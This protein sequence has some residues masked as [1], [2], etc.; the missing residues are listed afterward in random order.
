MTITFIP[1]SVT[2]W[3]PLAP[4]Q[5]STCVNPALAVASP[6]RRMARIVGAAAVLLGGVPIAMVSHRFGPDTRARITQN[7]ARL[8][9]RALGVKVHA[10]RGFAF[11]AGAP[12]LSAVPSGKG[13][14][15]VANHISWLDPLVM[16]ATFPCRPLA[17]SEVGEWPLIRTLARGAGVLFIHRD[18]LMALPEAVNGVAEA[19]R[20]GDTVVAFP[21]GTTW[22]GGEMGPFRPAVFQAA[23]DAQA[24]VRPAT[25]HY[26]EQA[27]TSA[28]ACY[29]GGD[30]LVGSILRVTSTKD[31]TVTV[32]LFPPVRLSPSGRPHEARK[33][34]ASVAEAQVRTGLIGKPEGA[35]Q[36]RMI[37]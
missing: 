28:R 1:P 26:R 15:L 17:K 36:G 5:P 32:T 12:V 27:T 19:L 2:A 29:V 9:L 34:L 10:N 7:W 23:L 18:R 20:A 37:A 25:I 30:T 13:T 35:H 6:L 11:L 33:A 21:E 8:L 24:A 31:M 3:Q 14:L 16:A 4:C 22:C